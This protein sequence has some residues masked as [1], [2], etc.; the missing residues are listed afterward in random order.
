MNKRELFYL[1]WG[2]FTISLALSLTKIH[3]LPV[4]SIITGTILSVVYIFDTA[5][6]FRSRYYSL[7]RN[8]KI[9]GLGWA[10]SIALILIIAN[11]FAMSKGVAIAGCLLLMGLI[12][13]TI[14]LRTKIYKKKLYYRML[15][16]SGTLL[17]ITCLTYY[18][19]NLMN[20]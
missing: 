1:A 16:H 2:I 18:L 14:L 9:F 7:K 8:I 6:I 10:I 13:A 15:I 5:T 3:T 17:F 19:R 4:L 11:N 20:S 12:I